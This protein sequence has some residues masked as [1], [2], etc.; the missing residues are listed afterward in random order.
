LAGSPPGGRSGERPGERSR[1]PGEDSRA[2]ART[3]LAGLLVAG[4]A[5]IVYRTT[6][7]PGVF[8]W[9]TAEAQTVLPL[10][11]T[12]HPTGFPAF[13]LVG[14]VASVILQPLGAEAF[15]MNL[16][17]A[18]LVAGAVGIT[19]RLLRTLAVPLPLAVAG[20][21]GLALTPIA[22]GISAAA[23]AHALH[24]FLLALIVLA[25]VR[26]DRLVSERNRS[27]GD[28]AAGRR[29][30]RGIV[31]AAALFGVALANH[32]LTILLIPAVGL[33][34]LAV[35]PGVV[36]RPRLVAAALAACFGVA[37][38]L[39]LELPLRAGPFPAPLVYGHPE[40]WTGFWDIVLAR[41]FQ[42]STQ[43]LIAD[44]PVKAGSLAGFTV[45]QLGVLAWLVPPAFVVTILRF[46]RYALL[47]GVAVAVTCLFAAYYLNASIGRYYLGPA[48]FAWSWLAIA[49]ATIA[50]AVL[51][52][53]RRLA[54]PAHGPAATGD[55]PAAGR[56]STSGGTNDDPVDR[57]SGAGR[58]AV[59]TV[60]AL[61]VALAL[62]VPTG[63]AL[64]DRWQAVDRSGDTTSAQWLDDAMNGLAEGAVVVSWWSTSTPLWYGTL[65]EGRRPDLLIV[66]DSDIVN[67]GLGSV[68]DVIDHYLGTR[69]VYVIRSTA[70]DIEALAL[71]YVLEPAG[72]PAGVYR[73]TGTLETQP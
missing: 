73:V 43:G 12:M 8:A 71:R 20:A 68:E 22:W 67:D 65:V 41:Q 37:G 6:L 44:L 55:E 72:R 10:M 13:V 24:L 46:P 47:S 21:I 62:L 49:A 28:P 60:I 69:P 42:G 33:Y 38:L 2:P 61:A 57:P 64:Q 29:A 63:L 31:L 23:D 48:L 59:R 25:L 18:L 45:S 36:R 26:W 9:D 54:E 34:V 11:G 17:S 52:R 3:L 56:A 50:E 15:R 58:R 1:A 40:T 7:L 19:V 53:A 51:A 30:D 5:L 4:A 66:D 27:R 70:A 35:D 16:L 39:Y 32:G 14:W